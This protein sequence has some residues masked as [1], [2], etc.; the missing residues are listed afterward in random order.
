MK[1]SLIFTV[2]EL[3]R[4]IKGSLEPMYTDIWVEG[5]ISNMRIPSSG[6]CYF[7]LKDEGSQIRSVMFRFKNRLLRFTPEHGL[8]VICRGRINIYE[9]R[10]EYQ[11]LIEMMEPRGIGDLQVAFEQLKKKLQQEGLFSQANKKPI[12]FLPGRIAVV[13][14]STGAAVRDI[15]N[16]IFRRFPNVEL[17]V[18]PVKVQGD[19][20]PDEIAEALQIVN[21]KCP[22]DVII[23]TRGGGSIED[24]WA[25]NTEKV[26]RAVFL[27]QIPVIS[28][29]GH[30][31][32][33]TLSDFVADLRAPTPSA[34]AE[35]VVKEKKELTK[36]ISHTGFR[37]KNALFQCIERNRTKAEYLNS[38]LQYPVKKI[39]DFQLRHDDFHMRLVQT[40]PRFVRLKRAAIENVF[41]VILS[42]APENTIA[43]K[44]TKTEYLKKTLLR[45]IQSNKDTKNMS[46]KNCLVQL[47]A[48]N[49]LNVLERGYS[50]TKKMPSME[51]VKDAAKL[52]QDDIVNVKFS[53]GAAD[54]KVEKTFI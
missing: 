50:I 26:V 52:K 47:N 16:I 30:E 17:T 20:A 44:R 12:P 31:I 40:I 29:V 41:K 33:F 3:T 28:A 18:V 53:R 51:I 25:F 35:L 46:L 32:D 23:L 24:L 22:A 11:L 54:C 6:H 7:T 8:K 37:L 9:P 13:T 49:P 1:N 15:I 5:E 2:T 45:L 36:L 39:S 38:H 48:I 4:H 14:S 21:E 34:A 19:E 43:H 42:H 10:G 27:S